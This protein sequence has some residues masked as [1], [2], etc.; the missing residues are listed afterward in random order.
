MQSDRRGEEAADLFMP[1]MA[2]ALQ[3]SIGLADFRVRVEIV[4]AE[5][6]ER[7][8]DEVV[9][10]PAGVMHHILRG[11]FA[12]NMQRTQTDKNGEFTLVT[13][14]T[15]LL[16]LTTYDKGKPIEQKIAVALGKER[17]GLRLRVGQR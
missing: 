1:V 13:R 12:D 14:H 2:Y 9:T 6:F 3:F 17:S 7:H 16:V 10:K 15:G 5:A 8:Q 4:V 11:G